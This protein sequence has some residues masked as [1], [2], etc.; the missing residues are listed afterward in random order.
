MVFTGAIQ[1]CDN[2]NRMRRIC[3]AKASMQGSLS[4]KGVLSCC[5]F[6]VKRT[7]PIFSLNLSFQVGCRHEWALPA[8]DR[9]GLMSKLNHLT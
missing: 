7:T 5:Y 8:S 9:W 3:Q 1:T 4:K 6:S 2:F